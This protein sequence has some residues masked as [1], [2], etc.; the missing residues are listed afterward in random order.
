MRGR[1]WITIRI[2]VPA[3]YHDL[4]AGTLALL[5]MD[6]FLQL[7][8]R[9]DCTLRA[10]RW[11]ASFRHRFDDQLRRFISQFPVLALPYTVAIVK[12]ENWNKRWESQAGIVEA[13]DRIIIKPSWRKLR[14][15]DRGKV[16]LHIDPKMA[17]GTGH[18]ETTRLCLL[19]IQ[20][21]VF[22]GAEVLDFGCGTGVLAIASAKLGARRVWAVDNDAW[23]IPNA[24][25]NV[26]RNRV[27]PSV[28]VLL[29]SIGRVP[30]KRFDLVVA[31]IDS[32]TISRFLRPLSRK[33]KSGGLLLLSG[34]LDSDLE[35]LYT[36]AAALRLAP[37]QF[38]K[39]NE[40]VAAAFAH[41]R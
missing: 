24:R 27:H 9:L 37:V 4:L 6:G 21:F 3:S 13:T 35:S 14:V 19:L 26:R 11:T 38:I 40:W 28:R 33:I 15:K 16:V 31:N 30:R 12:E 22:P 20:D 5:G 34:I 32:P 1:R 10:S 2:S 23:A 17:F 7:E 41:A 29:G 18:H 36:Q 25:E 8:D 39:E